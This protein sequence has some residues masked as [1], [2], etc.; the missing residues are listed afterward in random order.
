[1]SESGSIVVDLMSIKGEA[2]GVPYNSERDRFNMPHCADTRVSDALNANRIVVDG[3]NI[4][5]ATQ[6]PFLH[7]VEAQLQMLLDNHTP[8]LIVLA[9]ATDIQNHEMPQYF[10]GSATYG[11]FQTKSKFV[12]YIDLGND[13]ESK[14]FNFHITGPEASIDIPVLHVH[15]WPDHRTVSPETTTTLVELIES[16]IADSRASFAENGSS[17]IHND[18]KMLPVM[19]CKAGVGRTGQT[20]AA[21]VMKKYPALSLESITRDLRNSRNNLMIQSPYQMKT[22]VKLE[23]MQS[24]PELPVAQTKPK[25][26]FFG[27]L[28]GS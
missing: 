19:H 10:S 15:N 8:V 1:M 16:T 13:I 21:L 18:E 14:V 20:L 4:A 6:F 17:E 27:K 7:Q 24:K 11:E 28:F 26:S 25:R 3:K 23:A 12:D 2:I 5:I 22:L 9:S